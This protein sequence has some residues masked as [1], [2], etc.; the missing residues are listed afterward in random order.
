MPII[1]AQKDPRILVDEDFTPKQVSEEQVGRKAFSLFNLRHMDVPVPPF[2]AISSSIFSEF[3][4]SNIGSIDQKKATPEEIS[5]R[6]KEGAFLHQAAEEILQGYSRLSGFSDTWVSVR[7]SIVLP[8]AKRSVSFAG[9]LATVLN[10]RGFEE[11]LS[12]IKIV[13]ASAFTESV[14][15]YLIANGMSIS[16]IKVGVVVQKM[17]Q[18]EVSGIAFTIDPI[19]QNPELLTIE[20][21]FGL[22]D[23]IANGELTPDQYVIEKKTLQYKEK[24][25]VPQEWMTVRRTHHK[26]GQSA[27]QKIR[28]S[29]AWQHQPKLE[30]RYVEELSKIA[31]VIEKRSG[32]PQDIEWVFE[33]GRIWILQTRDVQPVS[34]PHYDIDKGVKIDNEI[35]NSA[36]EIARRE[37][38]RLQTKKQIAE[39]HTQK[40]QPKTALPAKPAEEQ[41]FVAKP[42]IRQLIKKAL[43]PKSKTNLALKE[44]EKLIVTGIGAS[45][46]MARGTARIIRTENDAQF[47]TEKPSDP[48]VIVCDAPP[49]SIIDK[50]GWVAAVVSD[51]GGMTSDISI[52]CREY[53]VPCIMGAG[54]ASRMLKDGE[55]LLVD[56]TIGAVYGIRK[57]YVAPQ[58]VSKTPAQEQPK[59][60]MI[61]ENY[62]KAK[63]TEAPAATEPVT[64]EKEPTPKIKTATKLYCDITETFNNDTWH[65]AAKSSD[66]IIIDLS[67]IYQKIGKHPE[68]YFDDS[69]VKD[70]IKY[71]SDDL[72]TVCETVEGNPVILSFGR[73][74]VSQYKKLTRGKLLEKWEEDSGISDSSLGLTRLLQKPREM[75]AIF[76]AVKR[77]RNV[78]NWR[79]LSI[80]V[81]Y[82]GTPAYLMEFKKMMTASGLR[83]SSTFKLFIGIDTPSEAIIIDDFIKA[84]VDGVIFNTK[85]LSKYMMA[86]GPDDDS[87]SRIIL[88]AISDNKGTPVLLTIPANSNELLKKAL[89]AGVTSVVTTQSAVESRRKD[90]S[91]IEQ[92]L[93]T[94]RL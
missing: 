73:M 84:G 6:I 74:P 63:P 8:V 37:E 36:L 48:I 92:Q 69:K 44:N 50:I 53:G 86:Q 60:K 79:N 2:M 64:K 28:I 25:I 57:A 29:K 46:G 88:K 10:V 41:P 87:V 31:L 72:A 54:I 32:K 52:K 13:Y 61:I 39:K 90:I 80:S 77:T 34:V 42:L 17:V 14:A 85:T 16:D 3:I 47:L 12:A 58:P 91:L 26:P 68:A 59:R 40:P 7:S 56:G 24:R 5:K 93:I 27:E 9:Q 78:R 15:S 20:A 45:A 65:K 49:Q 18:A 94:T 55:S 38:A 75:D 70:L 23:V 82:P 19:S 81:E 71:I 76:R 30:P 66:G 22:G 43:T 1:K 4:A 35:I 83:R 89:K 67:S 21:I 62:P 33:G 11:L 51:S